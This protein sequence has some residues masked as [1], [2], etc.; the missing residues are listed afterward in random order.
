MWALS[1]LG[2]S[3]PGKPLSQKAS[4][5]QGQFFLPKLAAESVEVF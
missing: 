3:C 5:P 4:V 2:R 1:A